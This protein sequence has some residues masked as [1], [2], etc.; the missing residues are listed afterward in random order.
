[1]QLFDECRDGLTL[2]KL[3]NDSVPDT[4]D[5]RVLNI[6]TARKPPQHFPNHREQQ[7]RHHL[8][9]G[10]R[11]FHCQRQLIRY[12]QSGR[13][14]TEVSLPRSTL[15]FIPICTGSVRRVRPSTVCFVQRPTKPC[16]GG[17]TTT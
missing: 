5:S 16:S 7:H 2:C 3:I 6:P 14:S 10:Y 15:N 12:L 17:S 9:Q 8:C 4:I 1:M 13:P 11:L